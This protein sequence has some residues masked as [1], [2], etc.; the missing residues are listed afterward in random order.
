MVFLQAASLSWAESIAPLSDYVITDIYT[1]LSQQIVNTRMAWIESIAD[2]YGVSN[3]FC[4]KT[5]T[6]VQ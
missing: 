4:R 6:L 1:A 5:K 3:N 2:P